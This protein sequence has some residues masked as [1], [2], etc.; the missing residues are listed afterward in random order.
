MRAFAFTFHLVI[1]L[2]AAMPNYAHADKYFLWRCWSG[3]QKFVAPTTLATRPNFDRKLVQE[4]AKNPTMKFEHS[5][6]LGGLR[7]SDQSGADKA[8]ARTN[9]SLRH[10][11]R[12]H[13]ELALGLD[14]AQGKR[15]LDAAT[16]DGQL[17]NDLREAKVEAFGLDIY[18]SAAQRKLPYFVEASIDQTTLSAGQFHIV[19]S[20]YGPF[21][22]LHYDK[23]FHLRA[24]KE[25]SRVLKPGGEIRL[26]PA[27][28]PTIRAVI[29]N[30]PD[31]AVEYI[32]APSLE[33]GD[34]NYVVLKKLLPGE[35][36]TQQIESASSSNAVRRSEGLVIIDRTKQGKL[37]SP[38]R[39][40]K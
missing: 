27:S 26:E 11:Q 6:N 32:G 39:D 12:D 5:N 15:V 23:E 38:R 9:R 30:I 35:L 10:F 29:K 31:L 3:F 40:K 8:Y 25:L 37:N 21:Y 14:T 22:Y 13:A 4:R 33:R 2:M 16:G 34:L 1:L 24:L 28:V 36:P 20:A 7:V 17:V 19:I 18:L